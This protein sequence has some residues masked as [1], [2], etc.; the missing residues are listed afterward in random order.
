MYLFG[1]LLKHRT[2]QCTAG[3]RAYL[4]PQ[5]CGVKYDPWHG[6]EGRACS[7]DVPTCPSHRQMWLDVT[8][9]R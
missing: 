7:M 3:Q 2:I 8:G 4:V 9:A 6:G 5:S 1:C